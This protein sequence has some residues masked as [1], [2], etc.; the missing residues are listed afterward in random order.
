MNDYLPAD[1]P[2]P[3]SGHV[4]KSQTTSCFLLVPGRLE[5]IP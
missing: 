4:H 3:A 2:L 1:A 5:L